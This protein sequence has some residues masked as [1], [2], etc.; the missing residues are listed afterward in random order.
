MKFAY[1]FSDITD[2]AFGFAGGKGASLCKMYNA[3]IAVPRRKM[4]ILLPC[5][6]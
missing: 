1:S 2:E 4:L 5:Q 6:G 3:G